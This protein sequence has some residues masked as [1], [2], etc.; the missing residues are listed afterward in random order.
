VSPPGSEV[1]VSSLEEVRAVLAAVAENVRSAYELC[2][3]ARNGIADA[4]ALLEP[5]GTQNAQPLPPAQLR[6]AVDE[7]ERGLGLMQAGAT[8]VTDLSARL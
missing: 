1:V 5:L 8:A 3:Q 6:R 2:G 4:V 7:L